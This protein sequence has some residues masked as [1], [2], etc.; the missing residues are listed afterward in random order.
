[1]E[2]CVKPRVSLTFCFNNNSYK[3]LVY[4]L[5]LKR[6]FA[7]QYFSEWMMSRNVMA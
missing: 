4:W 7:Q 1:M 6:Q 5:S 2:F 3:C